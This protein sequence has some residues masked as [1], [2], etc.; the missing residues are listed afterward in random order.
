MKIKSL[1]D[2]LN[3]HKTSEGLCIQAGDKILASGFSDVGVLANGLL[4]L[5]Y[6]EE[7]K[8]QYIDEESFDVYNVANVDWISGLHYVGNNLTYM[9]HNYRTDPVKKPQSAHEFSTNEKVKSV[10]EKFDGCDILLTP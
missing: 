10:F 3:L 1:S 8:F 9:G 6:L 4:P 2:T 5:V 7:K